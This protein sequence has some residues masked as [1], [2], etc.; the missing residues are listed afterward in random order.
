M[1]GDSES[2]LSKVAP[3]LQEDDTELLQAFS[4]YDEGEWSHAVAYL[5]QYDD[6]VRRHRGSA[7]DAWAANKQSALLGLIVAL[8]E[9]RNECAEAMRALHSNKAV[10]RNYRNL[11]P[12]TVSNER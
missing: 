3:L 9:A 6:R 2:L 5:G 4:A 10:L 12:E 11:L 8:T 1:K 7:D